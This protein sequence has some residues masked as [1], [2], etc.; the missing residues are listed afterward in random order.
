MHDEL[1][2]ILQA[3]CAAELTVELGLETAPVEVRK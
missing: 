2:I 1:P 3:V